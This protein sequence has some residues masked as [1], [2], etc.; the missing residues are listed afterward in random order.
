MPTEQE[1]NA[2]ADAVIEQLSDDETVRKFQEDVKQVGVWAN[3]IDASFDKVTRKFT[4]MVDKYG[5][6]FPGFSDYKNEW[7]GYYQR[8]VK[9][10]AL[11]RDVASENVTIL[12]RFD[13]IFL[14]MVESIVT[15]QDRKDVIVELQQFIDEKHDKSTEMS[16]GFLTLKR[17]IADGFVPRLDK[18]IEEK[19][20]ALREEA[21][22]LKLEIDG[23][24]G[25]I[26]VLDKKIKDATTAL[27]ACGGC[28]CVI[29]VVV[30]G[31][32]L[33]S[34]NANDPP[35][36]A[37]KL[38][39]KQDAL[40][41]VNRKQQALANLKTDFD[42]VKPDIALI[43]EKLVLFAEIWSSVRSQT[44]QFQEHLKG[45]MEAVTNL[46]FKKEVRLARTVC[47]PLQ[48]GL[49]KYATELENRT[50]K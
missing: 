47:G 42:G 22:K 33:A 38:Q 41:E 14:D 7:I 45:G 16:T 21:E 18:W 36:K 28:L 37:K 49:A 25:E 9:L 39:E 4:E 17:D 26:E 44:V 19:G 46:R 1:K 20:I 5:K 12:R 48:G 27:A 29:G 40:A 13:Q 35:D 15:D 10:L 2:F 32:V 31:S 3:Q 30:A 8:W 43:C 6:D 24:Q 50:P 23:L 11:S 34:Y